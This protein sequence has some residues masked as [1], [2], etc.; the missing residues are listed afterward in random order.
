MR[1]FV[2]QA[3]A[4]VV[5]NDENVTSGKINMN[6]VESDVYA[7]CVEQFGDEMMTNY[8]DIFDAVAEKF[9][10]DNNVEYC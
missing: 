2:E 7:E 8:L 10:V 4:R 3:F 6:F 1:K 9:I 5:A